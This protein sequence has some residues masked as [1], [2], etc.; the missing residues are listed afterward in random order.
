M[1]LIWF[2]LSFCFPPDFLE[3]LD[4]KYSKAFLYCTPSCFQWKQWWHGYLLSLVP[5]NPCPGYLCGLSKKPNLF[6]CILKLI[7]PLNTSVIIWHSSFLHPTFQGR[8]GNCCGLLPGWLHA[9]SLQ[10]TGQYFLF[11]H[12]LPPGTHY[13]SSETQLQCHNNLCFSLS[14]GFGAS[15]GNLLLE[16]LIL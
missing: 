12:F 8:P 13:H 15:S 4:Q 6:W 5:M 2:C 10:S 1:Y 9:K 3:W 14:S 16:P 11:D 7:K